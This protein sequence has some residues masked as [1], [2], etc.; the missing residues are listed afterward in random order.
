MR[1][2]SKTNNVRRLRGFRA[3]L[4]ESEADG[5]DGK[6]KMGWKPRCAL[7]VRNPL[8]KSKI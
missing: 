6:L 7:E 8:A 3:F 2:P 5:R 4:A 1:S